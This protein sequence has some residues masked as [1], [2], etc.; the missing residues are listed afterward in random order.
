MKSKFAAFK[1][2]NQ[3]I[4]FLG[5]TP[6]IFRLGDAFLA[7][8]IDSDGDTWWTVSS[9]VLTEDYH[10]GQRPQWN[11]RWLLSHCGRASTEEALVAQIKKEAAEI[12]G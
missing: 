2:L 5:R 8:V 12:C 4:K 10:A 6:E 11:S 3:E 7:V 1:K 9:S